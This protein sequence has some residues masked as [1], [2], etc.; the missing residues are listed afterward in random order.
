MNPYALAGFTV[1]VLLVLVLISW[2]WRSK[3]TRTVQSQPSTTPVQLVHKLCPHR[4]VVQSY[5]L[6]QKDSLDEHLDVLTRKLAE[7]EGRLQ[8]SKYKISETQ[9][10]IEN[11]HAIDHGVQQKYREVMEAL[12]KDLTFNER[13]CKR[14][15]EQIEWVSRRRA[16]LNSEVNRGHKLYGDA[17]LSLEANL[18][19]MLRGRIVDQ[20]VTEKPL[21]Q[22]SITSLRLRKEPQLPKAA[23][24]TIKPSPPLSNQSFERVRMMD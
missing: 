3:K 2:K 5:L 18:A 10:E 11:L 17:A 21:N 9:N 23:L 8:L 7:K 12:R 1:V 22:G 20:R 19:E 15:Q 13:E 24:F 6:E 4:N 14:L 16:E